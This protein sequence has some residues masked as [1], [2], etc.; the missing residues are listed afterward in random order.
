[1]DEVTRQLQLF[2]KSFPKTLPQLA[3]HVGY[4]NLFPHYIIVHML[5]VAVSLRCRP[6]H[7]SFAY[8]HP[9]SSLL[10]YE[11]SC[12][13][14]SIIERF[15]IGEPIL[16][17]FANKK[18][19]ILAAAIWY[20]VFFSPFDTVHKMLQLKLVKAVLIPLKEVQRIRVISAGVGVATKMYPGN[21]FIAALMGCIRGSGAKLLMRPL[22]NYTRGLSLSDH[23]LLKPSFSTKAS[24][25]ASILLI[26]RGAGMLGPQ[27]LE[28][29]LML[30]IVAF[31][32]SQHLM[33]LLTN[34][35]DPF[36]LFE[37][38]CCKVAIRKE[39]PSKTAE[40]Q[41]KD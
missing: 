40:H 7:R 12:F 20:L 38:I 16:D 14:G 39:G 23:E 21:W 22:D 3:H 25:V 41:K 31:I 8:A 17:I 24:L 5:L 2:W 26:V 32:A 18:N 15:L 11:A 4:T 37:D 35:G 28:A 29:Q 33:Q 30:F 19:I 9:L 27:L 6:G 1:M 36:C 13:G 34:A 10:V